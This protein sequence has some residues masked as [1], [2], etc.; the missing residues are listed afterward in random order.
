MSCLSAEQIY[1]YLEKELSASENRKI[2]KHLSS[3]L[4]CHK[5]LEERKFFLQAVEGLP[6]W[7]VPANFSQQVMDRIFPVKVTLWGWLLALAGGF[8]TVILAS[9]ICILATGQNLSSLFL[10]LHQTMWETIKNS[11]LVFIKF[12]KVISI[13]LTTTRQL[14]ESLSKG[15]LQIL[16][17]IHP[18]F[19]ILIIVIFILASFLIIY[20]MR[21]KFLFGEKQ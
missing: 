18:E 4:K 6:S 17:V 20:G 1:T 5:A 14:L 16:T 13:L 8:L 10:S 19:Q 3:C 9:T 2:E 7:Q 15:L 11:F 21:R 12:F